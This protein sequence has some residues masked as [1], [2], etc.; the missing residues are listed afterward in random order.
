[1]KIMDIPFYNRPGFK[2]TRNGVQSLDDAELLSI[3]FG[4]GSKDENA[5]ELSNRLLKKYNLNKLENLSVKELAKECKWDFNKALQLLS[6][7]EICKRY[8]K[9]VNNGFSTIIKS[10]KDVYNLFF[11]ELSSLK[12]EKVI[13]LYLDTKNK[14]IKK[15]VLGIGILDSSLIH[16]RELFRE[17]IKESAKSVILVH[18]HPSGDAN[19]SEDD[20]NL[21][22]N[23]I[24][25][26]NLMGINF[27]DHVVIGKN[28][29]Y[30]FKDDRI[31][32]V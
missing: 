2:L 10:S 26:S 1:M 31:V 17:A 8:N 21:T 19:P 5:I 23:L 7:V 3:I 4:V 16:P 25:A 11:N 6:L 12:K 22:K 9:L 29:F 32:R 14:I 24:E 28:C 20:I 13:G 15:E 18:N 27:L 30:S